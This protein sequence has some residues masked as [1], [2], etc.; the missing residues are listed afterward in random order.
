MASHSY[1]LTNLIGFYIIRFFGTDLFSLSF[2]LRRSLFTQP[3]TVRVAQLLKAKE[4][5]SA[6]NFAAASGLCWAISC[7]DL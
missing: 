1:F 5:T 7:C 3:D 6:R 4:V 2:L